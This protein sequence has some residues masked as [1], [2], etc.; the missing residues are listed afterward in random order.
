MCLV[1]SVSLQV[2]QQHQVKCLFFPPCLSS[3][4]IGS[5]PGAREL[6]CLVQAAADHVV[7]QE[8][9]NE[10]QATGLQEQARQLQS[11]QQAWDKQLAAEKSKANQ[12]RHVGHMALYR[13]LSLHLEINKAWLT[14]EKC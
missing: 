4:S 11:A 3:S 1:H 8:R 12:V 2:G 9:R 7:A 5:S 10:A 14:V 6:P 13:C